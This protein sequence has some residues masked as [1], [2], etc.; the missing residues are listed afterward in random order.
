MDRTAW[1]A[2]VIATIGLLASIY[3]QEHQMA[4]AGAK[5]LQQ[6]AVLAAQETPAASSSSS[7]AS[8]ASP[9]AAASQPA[10]DLHPNLASVPDRTLTLK[11]DVAE[12][13]FSNNR[14][15][16]SKIL[17]LQHSAEEGQ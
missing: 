17:L 3:W 13:N 11:S 7:P 15:G 6:Q 12:L 4:E 8:S 5:Y 16:L 9:Q 2:V 14:G 1:I 10:Q